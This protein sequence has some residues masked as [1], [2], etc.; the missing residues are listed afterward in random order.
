MSEKKIQTIS[1]KELQAIYESLDE[2]DRDLFIGQNIVVAPRVP[3]H[4]MRKVIVQPVRVPEMRLFVL[5][6]GYVRATVNLLPIEVQAQELIFVNSNSIVE[7]FEATNNPEGM[8]ILVS[9]ALLNI[10]C[11]GQ[12]PKA[13][14]G[15]V[16]HFKLSLTAEQLNFID[17]LIKLMRTMLQQ[18]HYEV[19]V[20]Q[21]LLTSLLWF[22]HRIWEEQISTQRQEKDREGQIFAKFIDLVAQH[23]KTEHQIGFYAE[24]LC[25]T[26][27]YMSTV[28]KK[29]SGRSAKEWIDEA[30]VV[31]I[32]I[33]LK[34]SSKSLK[35][36][37][38]EGLF[39]SM[40]FFSKF[41]KRMT[42]KTPLAYR[43]EKGEGEE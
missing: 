33:D 3:F 40:S 30:L 42:G 13:F 24:R 32:K 19:R 6:K 25:L 34:Y 15:D 20:F 35:E 28:V 16:R 18:P 36:I 41:F 27:R 23:A 31:A 37:A 22:V 26:P 2:R 12:V 29:V 7:S 14:G 43:Q 38:Y 4:I 5:R 10:V 8:G 1:V 21:P 17:A 9:P 11:A 39:P